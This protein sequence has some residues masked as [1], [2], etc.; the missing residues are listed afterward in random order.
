MCS[1]DAPSLD[2]FKMVNAF[3]CNMQCTGHGRFSETYCGGGKWWQRTLLRDY[4]LTVSLM[5]TDCLAISISR[6][7]IL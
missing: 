7:D 2:K 3:D 1:K 4:M 6:F 5:T